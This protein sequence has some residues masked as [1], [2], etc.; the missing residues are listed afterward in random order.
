[1]RSDPYQE[2]EPHR[3]KDVP[4]AAAEE[5]E[6]K[7]GFDGDRGAGERPDDDWMPRDRQAPGRQ[8]FAV[9]Q[10]VLLAL[11]EVREIIGEDPFDAR[12]PQLRNAGR[13]KDERHRDPDESNRPR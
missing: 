3:Y 13:A 1:E 12:M 6:R 7:E 4:R 11:K 2:R 5:H 10:V 8:R 9:G